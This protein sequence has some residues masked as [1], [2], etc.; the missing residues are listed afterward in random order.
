MLHRAPMPDIPRF[1]HSGRFRCRWLFAGILP[2]LLVV[3]CGSMTH[4]AGSPQNLIEQILRQHPDWSDHVIRRATDYEIQI[5][6]TQIDR[7]QNNFPEFTSHAYRVDPD[8]YFYPASTVKMPVAFL[9][10]E[11][12]RQLGRSHAGVGP[13]TPVRI[14]SAAPG[15][16]A[17]LHDASTP[18]G[19]P[20]IGHYIQKIFLVSDNDAHN[21]LYEF[22]GQ[23]QLNEALWAKGY[24]HVR[25][26]HR[27]AV[28][29]TPE[30][31]ACTNPIT[32]YDPETGDVLHEQPLVCN[33][34]SYLPPAPI[35]RGKGY[36]SDGQ[37]VEEPMN[38]TGKNYIAVGDLQAM[39]KAVL[40]PD[41]VPEQQRFD[42]GPQ[43]LDLI[44]RAM[45][46]LP[47]ESGIAKYEDEHYWDGYVKFTL[48]GDNKERIEPGIRVFNKVGV[49]Y[50]Y[51]TENAYTIDYDEGVEYLLTAVICV[52]ENGIFDDGKY[53]Y[54]EIGFPFLANLGRAIH[55]YEVDR[56]RRHRP[57]LSRFEPYR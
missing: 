12:I 41:A 31:N 37:L 52:N 55:A 7:D 26:N 14:D 44:Y 43:D 9:A 8:A 19:V 24:E 27:L 38:F 53:A 11:K 28:S 29:R 49:A 30:E 18:A 46:Q 5:L 32:F 47:R 13:Y 50:G 21:R 54:D 17:V 33:D 36:V 45:S 1:S 4:S 20:S 48:F 51:M 39:L 3:S 42:L 34:D 6:Y 16:I 57:D 23:K 2:W 25:L 40:F 22:L 56:P 10:L 15:Q 35:L